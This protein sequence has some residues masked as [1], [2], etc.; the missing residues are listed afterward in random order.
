MTQH[1][2]ESC[3]VEGDVTLYH[4]N[5]LRL[6]GMK[7]SSTIANGDKIVTANISTKYLPNLVIGYADNITLDDNQLTKSGYVIHYVV[8]NSIVIG[9]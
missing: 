5:R 1:S 4:E 8:V 6:T 2:L 3:M 7:L 9:M